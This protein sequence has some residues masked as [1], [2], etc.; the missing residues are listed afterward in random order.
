MSATVPSLGSAP[1]V[2]PKS[3]MQSVPEPG[4][5]LMAMLFANIYGLFWHMRR[6]RFRP[7]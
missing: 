5:L 6:R 1:T 7:V 3:D 4:S 2:A